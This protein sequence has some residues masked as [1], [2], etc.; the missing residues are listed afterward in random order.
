M[1]RRTG[2]T[3]YIPTLAD[4][5]GQREEE[6]KRR[7]AAK[8]CGFRLGTYKI[9]Y[10]LFGKPGE[11]EVNAPSQADAIELVKSDFSSAGLYPYDFTAEMLVEP[12]IYV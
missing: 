2:Q 5:I 4:R 12:N 7:E 1:S 8:A 9:K 10:M 3:D 11:R 6:E